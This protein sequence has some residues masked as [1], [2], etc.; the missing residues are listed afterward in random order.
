MKD[1]ERWCKDILLEKIVRSDKTTETSTVA[2]VH[3]ASPLSLK[4]LLPSCF[5]AFVRPIILERS[6][7]CFYKG[8]LSVFGKP[9]FS[10]RRHFLAAV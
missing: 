2:N 5:V 10:P 7:R 1:T 3:V 6:Q 8:K 4:Q 9:F